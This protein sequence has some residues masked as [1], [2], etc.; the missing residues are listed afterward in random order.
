MFDRWAAYLGVFAVGSP[1]LDRSLERHHHQCRKLRSDDN[2][3]Q[4]MDL[5]QCGSYHTQNPEPRYRL[6]ASPSWRK[7]F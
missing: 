3:T 2:M 7:D 5:N 6:Q 4:V 1:N